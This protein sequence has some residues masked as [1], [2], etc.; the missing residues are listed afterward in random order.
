[1][2]SLVLA[3]AAY[4]RQQLDE[5]RQLSAQL[6]EVNQWHQVLLESHSVASLAE[7][8]LCTAGGQG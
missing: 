5:A 6:S 1:M 3:L 2:N 4:L 8:F 7:R